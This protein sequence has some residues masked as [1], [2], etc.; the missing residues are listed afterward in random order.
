[1]NFKI[2]KLLQEEAIPFEFTL[3]IEDLED[4][5]GELGEDGALVCGTIEKVSRNTFLVTL[6]M[7]MTM[8]Y[9]CARCLEPTLVDCIYEYSDTLTIEEDKVILSLLPVVEECIY[10][11]EPYRILC[12]DGCEGLCPKCGNNLNHEQCGCDKISDY[13]HRFEA[14]KNLL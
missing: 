3:K 13:D 1:M 10:I 12:S 14:L 2:N 11:N 4:I 9:P 8:I 7:E 5:E 6:M